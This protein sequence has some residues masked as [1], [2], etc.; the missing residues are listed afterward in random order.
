MGVRSEDSTEP[1]LPDI[2]LPLEPR[3]SY[4]DSRLGKIY[5][6]LLSRPSIAI[7]RGD[8]HLPEKQSSFFKDKVKEKKR[9][10]T[11]I[12]LDSSGARSVLHYDKRNLC[13]QMG[14]R[15]PVRDLRVL[16][17]A[18]TTQGSGCVLVREKCIVVALEHVRIIVMKDRV[19][20]PKG[21]AFSPHEANL[22]RALERQTQ[23]YTTTGGALAHSQ[24]QQ[25]LVGLSGAVPSNKKADSKGYDSL[26]MPMNDERNRAGA[27]VQNLFTASSD[28][29]SS[30]PDVSL[31]RTA[32]GACP[33]SPAAPEQYADLMPFEHS[34]LDCAL[35]EVTARLS[36]EVRELMVRAKPIVDKMTSDVA[37]ETLLAVR[38]L[39]NEQQELLDRV[40]VVCEQLDTLTEEKDLWRMCLTT[41]DEVAELRGTS[42]SNKRDSS[43]H[44]N[45]SLFPGALDGPR[46]SIDALQRRSADALPHVPAASP[47]NFFESHV[48]SATTSFRGNFLRDDRACKGQWTDADP[49]LD[50]RVVSAIIAADIEHVEELIEAY[51]IEADRA[52]NRLESLGNHITDVEAFVNIDM[53][54]VRNRMIKWEIVLTTASFAMAIY[55]VVAGVLGENLP[56]APHSMLSEDGYIVVNLGMCLIC[57]AVFCVITVKARRSGLL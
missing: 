17:P 45:G 55:A 19:L 5:Q 28:L 14:L 23:E 25:S 31:L 57:T 35:N 47:H 20:V 22:M 30:H 27:A 53:D 18:F 29:S 7:D 49:T 34:V 48:P 32:S 37:R 54:A 21:E 13:Q 40:E 42:L 26:P 16:D 39:K 24:S 52:R 3:P 43:M 11:W 38:D 50:S 9:R 51:S 12:Q 10:L 2:G 4:Q 46:R 44:G 36:R 15:L 56:L 1:L 41:R 6:T 33:G 8:G